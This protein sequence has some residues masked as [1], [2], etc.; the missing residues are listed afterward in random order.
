MPFHHMHKNFLK[1]FFRKNN[2]FYFYF[3]IFFFVF[4]YGIW[5][6]FVFVRWVSRGWNITYNT[7]ICIS[8]YETFIVIR[9]NVNTVGTMGVSN[10]QQNRIFIVSTS[11]LLNNKKSYSS[12]GRW[13][14]K[15]NFVF[16]FRIIS[17]WIEYVN[18]FL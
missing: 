11:F 12:H 17:N 9:L 1:I 7:Y 10:S 3:H 2:I 8:L 15:E 18:I 5:S 6:S 4:A 14:W 13:Q 16:F